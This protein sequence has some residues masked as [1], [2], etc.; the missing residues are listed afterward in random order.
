M[1]HS[2]KFKMGYSEDIAK[3]YGVSVTEVNKRR[4]SLMIARW[5]GDFELVAR[6]CIKIRGKDGQLIPYSTP[7]KKPFIARWRARRVKLVWLGSLAVNGTG[8]AQSVKNAI[9]G[10]NKKISVFSNTY[11][12]FSVKL[13]ESVTKKRKNNAIFSAYIR[14][15][16]TWLYNLTPAIISTSV[17]LSTSVIRIVV[18]PSLR[19]LMWRLLPVIIVTSNRNYMCFFR[20]S[21]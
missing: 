4:M 14:L 10:A 11:Q 21:T 9:F 6:Q 16:E 5:K 13:I 12:F 18:L 3:P 20:V 8:R 17:I 15:F 2:E 1:F 7:L 19:G